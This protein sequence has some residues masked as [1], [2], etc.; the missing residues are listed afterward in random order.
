MNSVRTSE[1]VNLFN[2]WLK[3]YSPPLNIKSNP[4]AINDEVNSLLGVL[5]KYSP[6]QEYKAYLAKVFDQLEYQ[7]KTRAWPTKGEL[8]AVCVNVK[9]E[10]LHLYSDPEAPRPEPRSEAEI[11][12]KVMQAGGTVPETWLIGQRAEELVAT[13]IVDPQLLKKYRLGV[14]HQRAS[15]YGQ[16]AAERWWVSTFGSEPIPNRGSATPPNDPVIPARTKEGA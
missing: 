3:R 14:Y 5:V 10:N 16:S 13:G 9:K 7:M 6:M 12:A 8:G 4:E 2:R 15:L 1:I 11:Y